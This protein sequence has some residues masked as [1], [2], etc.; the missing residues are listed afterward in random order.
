M[1]NPPKNDN[2]PPWLNKGGKTGSNPKL[3]ARKRVAARR[4]EAA[5]GGK[6]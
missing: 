3:D 6:K 5:K 2:L 4:L 1:Q